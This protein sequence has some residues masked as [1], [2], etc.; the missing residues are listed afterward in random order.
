M[1]AAEF[2]GFAVLVTLRSP[3]YPPN[4][5]IK[6]IVADVASQNLVL[7][8]V[9]LLWLGQQVP[10]YTIKSHLIADL[11]VSPSLSHDDVLTTPVAPTQKTSQVS[12]PAKNF[13]DPAIL[14]YN[15]RQDELQGLPSS[16]AAT[17][18]QPTPVSPVMIADGEVMS[19]AS[20]PV[21]Q[22]AVS[23]VSSV[24]APKTARNPARRESSATATLTEPFDAM[25]LAGDREVGKNGA[26]VPR[27]QK[28]AQRKGQIG[29]QTGPPTIE[30]KDV[31]NVAKPAK[32]GRGK[33]WR[34][35]PMVEDVSPKRGQKPVRSRKAYAE[36]VNGWATEDAT[37]IQDLG[38]FDFATNL[39][40]FDKRQVFDDI[41]RDDN[42]AAGDR[43]VSFNRKARPGTD[44]GR[45]LHFTENVLSPDA[46]SAAEDTDDHHE[47]RYSSGRGSRRTG[48][49]KPQIPL[50]RRGTASPMNGSV[51]GAARVTLRI[52]KT[53]KPCPTLSPLQMLEI[54]SLCGSELGLTED[55]LAENAGRGIAGAVGAVAPK[56]IVFLV[57]NHKT[58]ARSI[59]AAR[60][61]RNR[62]FRVTVV[63]LG[64]DREDM[65]LE[66]VRRQLSIYRKSNGYVDRWDEFQSKLASGPQPDVIVDALMGMHVAFD[67][68]R[69][70]DQA[71]TLEMMRWMNRSGASVCSI[72][73]P[74]GLSATSGAT[75]EVEGGDALVVKP[76]HVLCTGA[77]KI[78]LVNTE[79][80]IEGWKISVIDVG[81]PPAAWQKYGS[82][83]RHGIEFGAEWVIQLKVAL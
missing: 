5:Q 31:V 62:R 72:D 37:D 50:L 58:G 36:D 32:R 13:V 4:A 21:P 6:G 81:I 25:A 49:V 12:Q 10:S 40:K 53:N 66:T 26:Q 79:L 7:R 42:V 43:L 80:P 70:D 8:D 51:S 82:R 41:R 15:R 46:K 73:V 9:I 54:E 17:A 16:S 68:L 47:G 74:S 55:M 48:S 67:E 69:T 23:D 30:V 57:G 61:L 11:E 76:S 83:R 28:N 52:E 63:L 1:A 77:P 60:H 34:Q 33:G 3:P 18:S 27:T 56:S 20:R 2:V 29:P 71:T 24:A 75:T 65:L 14:S 45:N 78:G 22:G 19:P 39:S 35:T 38:D 44:G 59:V 64:G